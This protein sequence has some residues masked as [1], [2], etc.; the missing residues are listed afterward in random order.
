MV[1]T[2]EV[3]VVATMR[4]GRRTDAWS[5]SPTH[6]PRLALRSALL[7]LVP[8]CAEGLRAQR[9]QLGV[10]QPVLAIQLAVRLH[11]RVLARR[12]HV[13]R[14][15]RRDAAPS[16]T[17]LREAWTTW[18]D[19]AKSGKIRNRSGDAYK[20]SVLRSYET[21]MRLRVIDDLGGA[22]LSEISRIDLQ[23]LADRMLADGLDPSTIRNTFMPMRVIYRRAMH[24]EGVVVNPTSGLEL[25]A[26]RGARDRIASASEAALLIDAVPDEDRA[27]WA[28]AFYAGL[29]LGELQA[30]RD[31]DVDLPSGV[32]HV[33]RSWD[34]V[35][36]P[37][38]PTSRAGARKVPIVGALRAH[39][40]AHRLRRGKVGGLIF[41]DGE[42]AFNDDTARARAVR[43][44]K[45]AKLEPIGFHDA[46]HSYASVAIAAGVNAKALSTYMG[47][48]SITVTI[49]RYGHLMPGNEN[50][51]ATLLDRYLTGAQTG[52]Q[53]TQN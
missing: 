21:S 47:H 50:E 23:D 44:W 46:R 25:P 51:A 40:A 6:H 20:P 33:R 12:R 24:R 11:E 30:L 18:L 42:S 13:H 4:R 9:R 39:L 16:A 41:G 1:A 38:T 37:I 28:T 5:A 3:V 45:A 31:E 53:G 52:A 8:T 10:G 26:V 48:S 32:I 29:R 15:P 7:H 36:G 34:K 43:A 19:G 27:L 14:A 35:V 2:F 49:D 17:T 22:K